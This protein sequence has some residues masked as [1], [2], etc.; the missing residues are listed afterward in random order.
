MAQAIAAGREWLDAEEVAEVLGGLWHPAAR[1][2]ASPPTPAEAARQAAAI[3]GKVALKIRSRD[4]THKSDVGGVALDLGGPDARAAR[5]RGHAGA[6]AARRCPRRG[7]TDSWCSRWSSGRARIELILG[8]VEDAIFGPV[9]LFGQG[10]T[11][12][13]LLGDTTLELPPL[14]A[15]L[16]RAQ[17]ARTR[18]SRL[19]A[20]LSRQRPPPIS[21]RWSMR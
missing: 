7:S 5:G 19:L 21:T 9:I 3:G 10:G 18:V 8:V 11:L 4:I 15:A 17:I 13:E 12:V 14:N 1:P 2:A 6:G 20:R 16:A